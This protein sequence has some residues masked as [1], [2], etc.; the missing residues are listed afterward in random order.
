MEAKGLAAKSANLIEELV[1]AKRL[2]AE[3][4]LVCGGVESHNN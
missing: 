2:L 3:V 4:N 1:E